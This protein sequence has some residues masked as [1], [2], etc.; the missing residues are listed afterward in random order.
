MENAESRE[1][2]PTKAEIF[3]PVD[4][5]GLIPKIRHTCSTRTSRDL[6]LK[7][8]KSEN[9]IT[10]FYY[11]LKSIT[12]SSI[13]TKMDMSGKFLDPREFGNLNNAGIYKAA[14]DESSC[15]YADK[16]H[17]SGVGTSTMMKASADECDEEV[18]LASNRPKK[19]AGR[20][21]FKETRH[22]I[23]RG[24]RR[25]NKNKWVCE[26]REPNKKT[27]IWLGTHPTPEMAARAHDVAALALR[28]KL[29]CLNFSDSASLLPIPSSNDAREIRRAA[30]EAAEAFRPPQFGGHVSHEV[31]EGTN[32]LEEKER[33]DD[34]EEPFD[35]S[36]WLAT[37]AKAP[38]LSPPH[39]EVRCD[40][41][42]VESYE[43]D[44]SLWSFSV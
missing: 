26:V 6:L 10:P 7:H 33:D 11:K 16:A 42:Y 35:E 8:T 27:R 39:H 36:G 5:V 43:A 4:T 9:Y 34:D 2:S 28:G 29:A 22:P 37:M 25:K 19:S 20:R 31:I 38:L 12:K 41:D 3:S 30:T 44:C 13:V 14:A 1:N 21:I 40:W 24:V 17:M 32:I 18:I 15:L 23:Y